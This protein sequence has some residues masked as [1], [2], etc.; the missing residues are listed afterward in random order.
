MAEALQPQR[1]R[2]ISFIDI[3]ANALHSLHSVVVRHRQ[4]NKE[5][6]F[7]D[8]RP[9]QLIRRITIAFL[10]LSVKYKCLFFG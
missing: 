10:S 8:A 1:T 9:L 7:P 6:C 4:E 2:R 3:T 5:G